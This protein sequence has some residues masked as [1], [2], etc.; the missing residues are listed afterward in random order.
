[1]NALL[2]LPLKQMRR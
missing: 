2:K 1:M